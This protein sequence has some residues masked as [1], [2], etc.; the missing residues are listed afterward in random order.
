MLER[1]QRTLMSAGRSVLAAL[2]LA[3]TLSA[4]IARADDGI[5]DVAQLPRLAG[6]LETTDSRPDR[7]IY[8]VQGVV[9]NTVASVKKLMAD[10]GWAQ[11]V[12]PLD[13]ART[14]LLFKKGKQGLYVS[15]TQALGRPDQSAVYYSAERIYADVPFPVGAT[16]LV[17]DERR[18]YLNCTAPAAMEVNLDFYSKELAA[19]GWTPLTVTD[20]AA[21]WQNADINETTTNGARVWFRRDDRERQLPIVLTLQRLEG[22]K[23]GVEIKVAPFALPQDLAAGSDTG[24]L[25]KPDRII[26]AGSS[27]DASSNRREMKAVVVADVGV[28]L[29]FYRRELAAR[30]WKEES[31]GAVITP[32]NVTLN[33]TS[34]EETATLKL[35]HKYDLT[36]VSM[37]T[38]VSQA[39]LA[40]RA[41]AKKDADDKFMKDAMSTATALMAQD[42]VRRAAQASSLSSA[43]LHAMADKTTPVPLPEGAENVEFDGGDGKLEFKSSSSVKALA[44]FYR[45]SLKPLG[46]KEQPSVIS[47][48]NMAVM[49]FSKGGKQLSFTI[50]QMGPKVN[51][52]ADGSGLEMAN[53]KSD[54]ADNNAS[55]GKSDNVAAQP[56]EPEPDSALPVPKQHTLS[57]IGSGKVPGS[58]IPFRRELEASIPAD[59]ASVLAFYR[60]ELTKRGWTESPQ[61]SATKSDQV[62]LAFSSPDGPA[63]LKLGRRNNETTVNLTQKIPAV[64]AKADVIPK[65]GQAKLMFANMGDAEATITINKQNI[66]I[67]AGAGTPQAKGPTLDLPPGKYNFAVKVAGRAARNSAIEIAADDAWG[68]MIAPSGDVLPLQVY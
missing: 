17:F 38:Q 5:V 16:D 68:L 47:N 39:A 52:S 56:L 37:V 36:I 50:M 40:A 20:A 3:L 13:E 33:Y 9:P 19:S 61:G 24:G 18:P 34:P 49:E 7:V 15:F 12:R 59:L 46:W 51:V 4:P 32:D 62:Q 43:P 2:A 44:D 30:N 28:A 41:K 53:A 21:R 25:P 60:S 22:G 42:Q 11:Y 67:A 48:P 6:A 66:K 64:A 58:D 23:T 54:I 1:T 10:N 31:N 35:G 55:G 14:Y 45:G 63:L 8:T 26:S 27:G 29:A 65:P 57:S